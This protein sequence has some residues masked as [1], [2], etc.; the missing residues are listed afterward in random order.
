MQ[1]QGDH[2]NTNNRLHCYT[3]HRIMMKTS[4]SA[5]LRC[6]GSQ[7]G[8][9]E[10]NNFFHREHIFAFSQIFIYIMFTCKLYSKV[11]F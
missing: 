7:D 10:F 11:N 4:I 9:S 3:D 5:A 6:N 8:F 2:L 1:I